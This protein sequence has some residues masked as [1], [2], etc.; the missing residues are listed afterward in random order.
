MQQQLFPRARLTDPTTSHEAA[1]A[2]EDFASGHYECILQALQYYGPLGKDSI[3]SLT[4]LEAN[5]VAR[6]LK[7][8]QTLGL[9]FLTGRTVKSKANRNEREWIAGKE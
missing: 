9:I 5:Q 2:A 1:E 7:E 4:I 3:S 8:M 6:R